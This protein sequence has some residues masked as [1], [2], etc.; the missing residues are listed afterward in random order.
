MRR[1]IHAE[2]LKLTSTRLWLWLML[3]AGAITALYVSLQIGFSD[4]PDTWT[5]P[6]RT[7][8]GQR[9]LLATA[10]S[11]ATPLAAV[12]GAIGIAGELRHRTIT[13]TFLATPARTRVFVAK[14]IT[15]GTAGGGLGLACL[16]VAAL[17]AGPWLAADGLQLELAAAG[18]LA[19]IAGVVTASA[20][21]ALLG[22][23]IGAAV[24]DQTASV[25]GLLVYLFIVETILTGIGALEA[26]TGYL[27]G[28]ARSSLT[29][30]TLSTREFVPWWQG[31][32]A[33]L[34]Y[35]GSLVLLGAASLR[36][37]DIT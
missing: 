22:V 31:G 35:V 36:R 32:S 10:A 3:A 30:I 9:T 1:L 5:L 27:P 4:D 6:L 28:P 14:L 24:R 29:G 18:N 20:L 21:F 17:I 11:A 33:L 37:R 26:W 15:Y 16:T 7:I 19:T 2:V 23:G 34:V 25:V 8:D 12:L 13:A